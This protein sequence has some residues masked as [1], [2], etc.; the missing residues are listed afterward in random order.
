[1]TVAHSS[2]WQVITGIGLMLIGAA[3]QWAN[4]V[5]LI[6]GQGHISRTLQIEA[7]AHSRA[8][9]N[10]HIHTHTY[11]HS[12]WTNSGICASL[13]QSEAEQNAWLFSATRYT[14]FLKGF[15]IHS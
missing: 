2:S 1:M 15:H 9:A 11:V 3:L 4:K 8:I 5:V 14:F 10:K 13:R 6:G 7:S 12:P